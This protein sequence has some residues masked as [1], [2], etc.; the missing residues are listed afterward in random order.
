MSFDP[1]EILGVPRDVDAKDLKDA[2]KK[3]S[4]ETHP[5]VN[6]T[7]DDAEFKNVKQAYDLLSNEEERAFYDATGLMRNVSEQQFRTQMFNC[8]KVSFDDTIKQCFDDGIRITNFGILEHMRRS[9]QNGIDSIAE[10]IDTMKSQIDQL[11][12]MRNVIKRE[13]DEENLF[14]ARMA[15]MIEEREKTLL[16]HVNA[17]KVVEMTLAEVNRY[18]STT[19]MMMAMERERAEMA[20]A[21]RFWGTSSS[22]DRN[23]WNTWGGSHG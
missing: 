5:D 19:E 15:E 8:L 4:K 6:G 1:Y 7:G 2:F 17:H 21:A 3:R 20:A 12:E 23:P 22:T 11:T 16:E 14:S 9:I 10:K 13:D 18:K